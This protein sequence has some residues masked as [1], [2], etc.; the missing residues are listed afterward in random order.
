VDAV[1]ANVLGV[2]ETGGVT[3]LLTFELELPDPLQ[4]DIATREKR[5]T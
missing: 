5:Q 3:G 2:I 1:N 4:A